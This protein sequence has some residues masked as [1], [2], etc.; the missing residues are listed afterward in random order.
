MLPNGVS[1]SSA[2]GSAADQRQRLEECTK[3]A[4]ADAANLFD[5]KSCIR[6]PKFDGKD[7][8]WADYRWRCQILFGSLG[9]SQWIKEIEET[10]DEQWQHSILSME[11]RGWSRV[12]YSILAGSCISGRAA[13]ILRL[14]EPGDGFSVWRNLMK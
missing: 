14:V 10:S 8:Q 5:V 11:A 13:A 6:P 3:K 7:S 1:E 9:I 12:V 4:F 2:S